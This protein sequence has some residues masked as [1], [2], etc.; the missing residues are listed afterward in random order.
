MSIICTSKQGQKH[1]NAHNKAIFRSLKKIKKWQNINKA[2][3]T[4]YGSQI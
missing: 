1:I 4:L 3:D 2:R